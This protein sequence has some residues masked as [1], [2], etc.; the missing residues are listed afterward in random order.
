MPEPEPGHGAGRGLPVRQV[1]GPARGPLVGLPRRPE[2]RGPEHPAV[3]QGP[4][5]VRPREE[6]Q[7]DGLLRL[8]GEPRRWQV[9]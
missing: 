4:G 5:A 7:E 2:P 1:L 8:E 3:G 9:S 6:V